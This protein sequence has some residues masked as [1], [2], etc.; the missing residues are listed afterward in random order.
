M[1]CFFVPELSVAV[2]SELLLLVRCMQSNLGVRSRIGGHVHI[3]RKILG[4]QWPVVSR[5]AKLHVC[6]CSKVL[7]DLHR[8]TTGHA[9]SPWFLHSAISE[10][11]LQP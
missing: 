6:F 10:T 11:S 5:T 4:L 3:N 7:S 8:E 9:S 2:V 1:P